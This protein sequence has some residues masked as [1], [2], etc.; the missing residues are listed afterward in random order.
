MTP[1][2]KPTDAVEAYAQFVISSID[3]WATSATAIADKIQSG[4]YTPADITAETGAWSG[5]MAKAARDLYD[6]LVDG[7]PESKVVSEDFIASPP[8]KAYTVGRDLRLAGPLHAQMTSTTIAVALVDIVPSRLDHGVST[9][10]LELKDPTNL[11]GDAYWGK[12]EV[13]EG[14]VVSETLDVLIQ[15]P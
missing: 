4:S 12:V 5:R 2:P 10:H 3:A 14:G 13:V 8:G 7:P 15:V 6:T 1:T 11:P 9:F